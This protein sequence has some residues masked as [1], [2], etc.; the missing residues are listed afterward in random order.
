MTT[1]YSPLSFVAVFGSGIRDSGSGIRDR[2][3]SGSGIRN[4]HLGSAT[5]MYCTDL[6]NEGYCEPSR[7]DKKLFI[8]SLLGKEIMKVRYLNLLKLFLFCVFWPCFL[9]GAGAA[10]GF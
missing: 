2:L 5:L 7:K 6:V 8:C 9:V 4:K 1:I 3:K 10:S